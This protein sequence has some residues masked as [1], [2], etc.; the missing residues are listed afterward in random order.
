MDA[1]GRTGTPIDRE[2]L[3]SIGFQQGLS[4]HGRRNYRKSTTDELNTTVTEHW[5]GRQ[6]VTVRPPRIRLRA[7]EDRE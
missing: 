6:D 5:E 7:G 2:K 3:R 1:T 4:R